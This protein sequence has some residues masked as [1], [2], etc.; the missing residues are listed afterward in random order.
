VRVYIGDESTAVRS[1]L[2][3]MLTDHQAVRVVGQTA[4]AR[5]ALQ[6]IRQV[7]PEVVILAVHMFRGSGI[8]VA[9]AVR[10]EL[11]SS[12]I[13]MLTNSAY[14]QYRRECLQAGADYF[15]DKSIEFEKINTI[16]D[17]LGHPGRARQG[18]TKSRVTAHTDLW[19]AA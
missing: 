8:E 10:R 12:V 2:V 14:P 11:P 6:Q 9:R 17:Q 13:V 16:F 3:R 1:R 4:D 15:L 7:R 19:R 18:Q 5:E